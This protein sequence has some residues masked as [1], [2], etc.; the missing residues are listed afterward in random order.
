MD[1]NLVVSVVALVISMVALVGGGIGLWYA[2]KELHEDYRWKRTVQSLEYSF[3][4]L[5]SSE[6][7]A[8]TSIQLLVIRY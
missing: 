6:P 3:H 7:R 4:G 1:A 5:K 2:V 8:T